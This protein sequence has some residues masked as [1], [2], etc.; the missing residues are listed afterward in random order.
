MAVRSTFMTWSIQD[1]SVL[2][3]GAT[4]GI[5]AVVAREL[6]GAGA[7][8]TITARNPEKGSAT[9]AAIT[10]ETGSVVDV[11][12]VDLSSLDSVRAAARRFADTHDDLAVLVNNAGVVVGKRSHSVD[13]YELTFAT[14][15][16]GP[17]LLTDMLTG[18]L[19]ASAP[20]R[21]IN[22][23]SV[24]HT[25]AKEGILFDD[26][27]F[28]HRRY[29]FME[30][31]GHSKLANILHARELNARFGDDGLSA[32]AVHPGVVRTGLGSGGSSTVVRIAYRL[33]GRWMRTP[34]QGAD[35]IV[36]LAT[37]P[38]IDVG[39]DIYFEDRAPSKS[40]RHARDM[41]QAHRLWLVSQEM[42]DGR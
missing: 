4:S 1:R 23:S 8:V 32:F 6:A 26:L 42:T 39:D 5:G 21:V 11:L 24:A 2:V 3:T 10:A 29:K 17:F 13:G 38:S 33:G 20:S 31:Y 22:T 15:H 19:T 14:N 34:E 41:D 36:W 40:T 12:D 7:R 35:T 25:Y 9:A 30:V 27:G 16:L 18:L 37:G 28:E